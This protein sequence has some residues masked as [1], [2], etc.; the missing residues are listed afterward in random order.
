MHDDGEL[1]DSA[2]LRPIDALRQRARG[3]LE[4]ILPTM[5]CL[6]ALARF[7]T[8]DAFF[9]ALDRVP[10]DD[11]HRPFVVADAGGERVVL[12]GDDAAQARRW[13]IPLPDLDIRTEARLAAEGVS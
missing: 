11:E 12:P 8:A 5:R 4:L 7:P 9:A 13:T 10:R 2:W 1:V 3:D 6:E